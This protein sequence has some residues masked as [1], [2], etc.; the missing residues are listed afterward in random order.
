LHV[1][2]GDGLGGLGPAYE[3]PLRG[4]PLE[5]V[6][7]DLDGDGTPDLVTR[8]GLDVVVLLRDPAGGFAGRRV[9]PIVSAGWA[10]GLQVGDVDGDGRA[11]VLSVG[12]ET[13]RLLRNAGGGKLLP[14]EAAAT[15]I[16]VWSM[17]LGELD[18][19][20]T[21][22]SPPPG[23][24]VIA[25]HLGDGS[26]GFGR[27]TRLSLGATIQGLDLAD[28]DGD[29]R[30]EVLAVGSSLLRIVLRG[31]ELALDGP[32]GPYVGVLDARG[33]F[34]GDG[35]LDLAIAREAATATCGTSSARPVGSRQGSTRSTTS[36]G[37][38]CST[39]WA[40][41]SGRTASR[42]RVARARAALRSP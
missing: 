37:T 34:D 20:G 42:S 8:A 15:G 26:G 39:R 22:G 23:Q 1:Y 7:A 3:V 4:V 27:T 10:S 17:A 9:Y 41:P 5:L 32:I 14:V 28:L 12:N 6:V 31:G 38:G 13:V 11:D 29:G 30:D 2:P 33:D 24:G 35:H 16:P 36:T 40:G 18:G 21:L 25:A 19:D